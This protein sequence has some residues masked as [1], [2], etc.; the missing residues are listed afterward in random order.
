MKRNHKQKVDHYK[1]L[2]EK[3]NH[4]PRLGFSGCRFRFSNGC[5][6]PPLEPRLDSN[7]RTPSII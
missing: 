1:N 6:T 3:K 2:D 4:T 5:R 7:V